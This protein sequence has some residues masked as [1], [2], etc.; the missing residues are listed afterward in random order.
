DTGTGIPEDV[1]KR[2]FEPFFT[3][4]PA[5]KG[6]GLGLSVSYGIIKDH[7][8]I[9]DVE[10]KEGVGTTFI[11]ELPYAD[12]NTVADSNKLVLNNLKED[13]PEIKAIPEVKIVKNSVT[14]VKPTFAPPVPPLP[15]NKEIINEP[16]PAAKTDVYEPKP[17]RPSKIVST[18]ESSIETVNKS[19]KNSSED[20]VR[21]PRPQR[22]G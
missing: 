13:L 16:V 18:E 2:I 9:L 12:L 20:S 6:T 5:G 1:K 3:T 8:G 7:K 17:N 14:L 19:D 10:S 21:I 11:V 22:R 15:I 4:K